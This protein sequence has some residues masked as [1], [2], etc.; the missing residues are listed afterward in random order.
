MMQL[1]TFKARMSSGERVTAGSEE[2]ELF[3]VLA[4][5]ARRITAR[6]NAATEPEDIGRLFFELTGKPERAGF[7]LFPPFYTDCGKNI[8]V[9][10]RVFINACCCFQDQGGIEIGDDVLIGHGV[11]IATLDHSF[12]PDRRGD[13]LPAKV[14]IGDK[15]WIG[16]GARI[17]PGVTIGYGAVIGMGAVVTRDV[18]AYAIAAGVPARVIGDVRER[19]RREK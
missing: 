11:Y 10:E 5:E 9:G 6:L 2:H 17:V 15:V 3:H 8:T 13:M 1:E 16:S 19:M 14:K 4:L 18:P 12:D 7:S